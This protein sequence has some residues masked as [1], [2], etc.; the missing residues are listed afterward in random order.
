VCCGVTY[1]RWQ[2]VVDVKGEWVRGGLLQSNYSACEVMVI[3]ASIYN[4][5]ILLIINQLNSSLCTCKLNSSEAN[6]K[7]G[8]AKKKEITTQNK[9]TRQFI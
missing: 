2:G 1:H 6:Y 7:V 8:T 5:I 4:I 3:L 9:K